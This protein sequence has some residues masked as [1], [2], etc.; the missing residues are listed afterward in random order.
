MRRA[1]RVRFVIWCAIALAV[2]GLWVRSYRVCDNVFLFVHGG[3]VQGLSSFRGTTRWL[4]SAVPVGQSHAWTLWCFS[5]SAS[6]QELPVGTT[7][8]TRAEELLTLGLLDHGW[9]GF[10]VDNVTTDPHALVSNARA[11]IVIVP[12]WFWLAFLTIPL[13]QVAWFR[14]RSTRWR[15]AGCC[16]ACGYDLRATPARCPECGTVPTVASA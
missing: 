5:E 8:V 12:H 2:A 3:R 4:I 16:L 14:R 11:F 10:D 6:D 7:W 1:F 15:E 9:A 13:F